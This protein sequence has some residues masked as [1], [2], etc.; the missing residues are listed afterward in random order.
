MARGLYVTAI[1]PGSGKPVVALGVME[2]LLARAASVGY[3][4]PV[5]GSVSA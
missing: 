4:R 1:E 2:T 3:F 5:A